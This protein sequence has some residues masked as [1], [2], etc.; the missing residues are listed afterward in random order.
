MPPGEV[1]SPFYFHVEVE[2]RPGVLAQVAARLAGHQ[3]SVA[4]LV[5]HE[6]A[7]GRAALHVVVHETSVAELAAALAEIAQL[8]EARQAPTALPVVSARGVPGLGWT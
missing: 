4:R 6:L 8:A 1:R 7:S 2:D 3:V 5:Q